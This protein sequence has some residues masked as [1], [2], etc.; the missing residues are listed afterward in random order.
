MLAKYER[1]VA[2]L[3]AADGNTRKAARA[4]GINERTLWRW[5]RNPRF[6]EMLRAAVSSAFR[7]A[8]RRLR[9]RANEAVTTLFSVLHDSEAP[10]A[11]KV[12]GADA[13]LRRGGDFEV[14]DTI[15]A[16]LK[17]WEGEEDVE[18]P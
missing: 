16:G 5:Q 11:S 13:V 6:E 9:T 7:A 12:A 1:G 4:L 14:V 8:T 17:E 10:A 15:E 2:A 18:I 3:L